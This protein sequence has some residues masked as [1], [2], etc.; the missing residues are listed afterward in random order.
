MNVSD[1]NIELQWVVISRPHTKNILIGNV[2]RPPGGNIKNAFATISSKLNEIDNKGK[3]EILILG[4]FNADANNTE[5]SAAKIV[6]QFA[7]DKTLRQMIKDTTRYAK[8][9]KSTIDLAFTNIKYCNDSG[10][11]NYNISDHKPIYIIKKKLRNIKQSKTYWARSYKHY[12]EDA[13]RDLLNEEKHELNHDHSQSQSQ[14]G[15]NEYYK[16]IEEAILKAADRLCPVSEMRIRLH[17]APY[18]NDDL[19]DMQRDRDYFVKKADISMNPGDRFVANCLIKKT[20][21]EV[22]KAKSTYYLNQAIKLNQNHAKFW[23]NYH[24]IEPKHQEKIKG[25]REETNG[26]NVPEDK[27]PDKINN[28]FIDIGENLAK[29]FEGK[30]YL[31]KAKIDT[32]DHLSAFELAKINE[33]EMIK[34]IRKISEEKPSGVHKI[35]SK[36]IKHAL[37]VLVSEFTHLCNLVIDTGI[38]PDSWK[39]ATVTPIPKVNSPKTCDELRP[40]SILPLPG[41]LMEQII[42]D[43]IKE[44]LEFINFFAN[45]QNGFRSGRST[46]K[47]MTEVIDEILNNMNNRDFTLALYLDFKKAFDTIDHKILLE[48]LK[49]AGLGLNLCQL[50]K[51]YLTNRT[52]RTKIN[53]KLSNVRTV[54]TGVPQGSTLGPLLFIIFINDLPALTDRALFVL[55]ADDTVLMVRNKSISVAET[56]MNEILQEVDGWCINNKLTLNAKKT[57]YVIY[58]TKNMKKNQLTQITLILGR[59]KLNEVDS[60]KYLG[61]I[62][63]ATLNLD[64]QLSKINQIIA[65]KLSTFRKMRYYISEATAIVIYKSTI[66][67]ILDYNDIIYSLGTELQKDKMQKIQNRALRTIFRNKTLSTLEMHDQAKVKYLAERREAHTLA[68]MYRR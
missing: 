15:P 59:T 5:M 64:K 60:Y 23:R 48:K 31:N 40:I 24:Q 18:I 36:V 12:T 6:N 35:A 34:R 58:G 53:E 2:Y 11:L 49:N 46:T 4:D 27:L 37:M 14:M 51:N 38:F 26:E 42:H 13:L 52:Q 29:K 19:I 63:D 54:K 44:H 39:M 10:T 55:F 41:K 8:N 62:L 25:I 65:I 21:K 57:E 30:A 22:R 67:P 7:N 33:E 16:K 61:T 1:P 20:N 56:I 66:L 50:I 32:I 45:Q 17:T 3:Y 9:K 43:Q 47:A 28:F 68:L